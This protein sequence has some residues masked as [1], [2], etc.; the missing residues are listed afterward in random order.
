[1]R[2]PIGFQGIGASWRKKKSAFVA[3]HVTSRKVP[4]VTVNI[5]SDQK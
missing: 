3:P 1:M 2:L 5:M 4:A